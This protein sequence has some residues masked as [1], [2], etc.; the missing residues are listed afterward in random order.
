LPPRPL[1]CIYKSDTVQNEKSK[2]KSFHQTG[3]ASPRKTT[4]SHTQK[5]KKKNSHINNAR[6]EYDTTNRQ[7][8]RRRAQAS[9]QASKGRSQTGPSTTDSQRRKKLMYNSKKITPALWTKRTHLPNQTHR[10]Q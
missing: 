1:V 5:K 4:H 7:M 3:R 9:K 10:K 2:K 8:R 6:Y